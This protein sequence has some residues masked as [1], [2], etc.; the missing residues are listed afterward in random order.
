[1]CALFSKVITHCQSPLSAC[2][3]LEIIVSF[4]TVKLAEQ[5][6]A[7]V[8]LY[9]ACEYI[10]GRDKTNSNP[11]T[12]IRTY[13]HAGMKTSWLTVQGNMDTL[14]HIHYEVTDDKYT[15]DKGLHV[16]N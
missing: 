8:V 2:S 14:R 3:E 6:A 4:A 9:T 10:Y 11:A 16:P 13:G 5:L 7:N 1:M 12:H 15:W